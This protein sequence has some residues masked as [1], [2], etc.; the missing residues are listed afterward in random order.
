MTE[1]I[2]KKFSHYIEGIQALLQKN[3]T[4]RE[5]CDDYEELCTWLED[6]CRSQGLPSKECDHARELI[7]NLENDIKIALRDAGFIRRNS[8]G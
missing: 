5:I 1:H 7:R 6:Y 4:F 2:Y 3:A 8:G